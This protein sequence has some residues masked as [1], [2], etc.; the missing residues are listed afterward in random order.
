M[1]VFI[2]IEGLYLPDP[3]H[4]VGGHHV[5]ADEILALANILDELHQIITD[6]DRRE[7][8]RESTDI[9]RVLVKTLFKAGI[10]TDRTKDFYSVYVDLDELKEEGDRMVGDDIADEGLQFLKEI[11]FRDNTSRNIAAE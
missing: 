9:F 8:M 4:E 11:N 10:I 5:F 7:R 6:D 3:R 1:P 2:I